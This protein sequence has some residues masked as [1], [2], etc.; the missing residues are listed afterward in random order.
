[1]PK[2]FIKD[3]IEI[4]TFKVPTSAKIAFKKFFYVEKYFGEYLPIY[5]LFFISFINKTMVRYFYL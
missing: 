4:F 3:I 1:M 5:I 2:S